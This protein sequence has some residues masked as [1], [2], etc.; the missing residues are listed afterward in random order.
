MSLHYLKVLLRRAEKLKRQMRVWHLLALTAAQMLRQM[1]KLNLQRQAY[2]LPNT[3]PNISRAKLQKKSR[4]TPT[5][6]LSELTALR[7][8]AWQSTPIKKA[9]R[10]TIT[11]PLRQ[12]KLIR[13]NI[14]SRWQTVYCRQPTEI[15]LLF[16][17]WIPTATTTIL[18]IFQ[19]NSR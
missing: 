16:L 13:L 9:R 6:H 2:T 15:Q 10:L 14:L 12:K 17:I 4:P 3:R 5:Q 7:S 19:S 1:G 18:A 11:L 8:L